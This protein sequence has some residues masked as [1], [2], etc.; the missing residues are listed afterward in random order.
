M[1]VAFDIGDG[2]APLD[3]ATVGANDF[4]VDGAAPLDAK[5]NSTA[6]KDGTTTL[7]KGTAVYLQVGKLDTDARPKVELTGEVKDKAGNIRR[8]LAQ[9]TRLTACLPVLTV[10]PSAD[11]AKD[12]VTVTVSS[13]EGP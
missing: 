2:E 13:S 1:R 6:H 12:A 8:R 10:T 11:I 4:R 7:A 9:L 5:V 3:P